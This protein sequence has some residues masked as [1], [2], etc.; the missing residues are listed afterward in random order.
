[1]AFK[2]V[3]NPDGPAMDRHVDEEVLVMGPPRELF[4]GGIELGLEVG[5]CGFRLLGARSTS[6]SPGAFGD[7]IVLAALTSD[8]SIVRNWVPTQNSRAFPTLPLSS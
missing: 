2:G 6:D 3:K 8:D 1:L 5:L 4:P 7:E